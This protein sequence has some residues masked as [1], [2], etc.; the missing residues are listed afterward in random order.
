MG[1]ANAMVELVE[2]IRCRD[3]RLD[4]VVH[5][6]GSAGTHA[7]L[8]A[9]AKAVAPDVRI[10]GISVASDR[11]TLRGKVRTIA[12]TNCS[13]RSPSMPKSRTTT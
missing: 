13:R 11:E 9:A 12:D 7:G 5:A 3:L 4:T 2:Q 6:S 10:V 1:Y 8:V